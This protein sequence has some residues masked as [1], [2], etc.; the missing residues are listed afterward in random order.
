MAAI[1][2]MRNITKRFPGVVANDHVDF[3]VEAGEIHALIGE[4]GA[5]KTTLMN[6]LYGLYQADEGHIIVHNRETEIDSPRKAIGLGIGMVHQH[7][8]LVQRLSVAENVALGLRSAKGILLDT[9]LVAQRLED[10]SERHGLAVDPSAIVWQ[11][12]VGVQQRV[13]ILKVLYRGA[14]ILILDEPTAIL[15]PMN[16]EKNECPLFRRRL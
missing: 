14:S 2:S 13:E 3:D 16:P 12:P 11:L 10:L 6:I 9:E 15:T 4:N 7:F 1:L 8:M 5:G